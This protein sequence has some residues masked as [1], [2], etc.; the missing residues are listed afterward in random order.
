MDYKKFISITGITITLFSGALLGI[1]VWGNFF[2]SYP[3]LPQSKWD[4]GPTDRTLESLTL[5]DIIQRNGET[6]EAYFQ[7]VTKQVD[8]YFIHYWSYDN[9][10]DQVFHRIPFW[11][12]FLLS[13]LEIIT[14]KGY[15][16]EFIDV[17]EALARGYGQCSQFSLIVAGALEKSDIPTRIIRLRGHVVATGQLETGEWQILDANYG[18]V[19]PYDIKILEENSSLVEAYYAPIYEN[20][21]PSVQ[22]PMT[23][24]YG[25]EGNRIFTIIQQKGWKAYYIEKVAAYLNFMLPLLGIFIGIYLFF[26]PQGCRET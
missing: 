21:P 13:T 25:P 2:W 23:D 26:K 15:F 11:R 9:A 7:R 1:Q 24:I 10:D 4:M 22:L 3:V 6:R 12:N 14:D 20:I 5:Q 16:H 19:L 18:V 17:N 8:Q